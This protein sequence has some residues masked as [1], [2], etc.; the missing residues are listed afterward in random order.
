MKRRFSACPNCGARL[1][2]AWCSA[3]G[4]KRF[5]EADRRFGRLLREFLEAA[6]DLD[7]RFWRS[8]R[9]LVFEPG[10][11]S[12]DHIEGRRARW[13]SPVALFLFVNVVY[14]VFAQQSDFATPFTWEVP[15][16]IALQARDP[17]T[18]T[19]AEAARLRSDPGPL[20]SVFTATL[21]ERRIEERNAEMREATHGARG[22]GYRDYR[23]AYDAKVPEISK[24]LAVA[25]VP[26]LALALLL[27]FRLRGHYYTE[28]FVV[29]LHLVA[30]YM[31]TILILGEGAELL[32][33]FVP[34]AEWHN[35]ALNWTIR[36]LLAVYCVLALRR[37][38]A[39][40]W[41]WA[42][43]ATLG[44]FAAYALINFHLYRPML[45]LVVFGLT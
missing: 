38:Y 10:R 1:Y 39:V 45:F 40:G 43:T 36:T 30:F 2:G 18:V 16:R 24:A 11:L 34:S 5:V 33:R 3:C 23:Q 12:R 25:H 31:A 13:M 6:T 27:M 9:A 4:Q 8:L 7:G 17:G 32:H 42:A 41:G 37:A 21:V 19:A 28:H 14:F 20:H 29:A 44:L 35:T 15:G 22:Y 26:L